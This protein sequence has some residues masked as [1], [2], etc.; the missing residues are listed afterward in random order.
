MVSSGC[1]QSLL[2][3]VKASRCTLAVRASRNGTRPRPGVT[4]RGFPSVASASRR[5]KVAIGASAR[6]WDGASGHGSRE[7]HHLGLG[8][9][10]HGRPQMIDLAAALDLLRHT[11]GNIQEQVDIL[12]GLEVRLL[13]AE[14]SN[15][16]P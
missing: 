10:T 4:V 3:M 5:M 12:D 16:P 1:I 13:L 7:R 8:P 6:L 9:L 15:P 11:P 14:G 2:S